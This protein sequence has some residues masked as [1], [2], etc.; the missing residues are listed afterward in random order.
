MSTIYDVTN[1]ISADNATGYFD[2]R[3]NTES[4]DTASDADKGKAL[5]QATRIIDRL[6]IAGSKTD[7][8]QSNQFPRTPDL[9][10][11]KDIQFACAE[12]ALAL[13]DGAEPEKDFRDIHFRSLSHGQ[14]NSV[15]E[16]MPKHLVAGVPSFTAWKLLRPY[17]RDER[18]VSLVRTT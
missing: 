13:L 17:L 4:W 15:R 9:V 8:N 11:P 18:S 16:E 10:V 1:Y 2:T 12:I 5:A 6:P 7:A 14:L 3:L